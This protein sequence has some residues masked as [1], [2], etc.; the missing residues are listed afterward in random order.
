MNKK[1]LYIISASLLIAS[2]V[3]FVIA[4][5][6]FGDNTSNWWVLLIASAVFIA[7]FILTCIV[8]FRN[9]EFVCANCNKQFKPKTIASVMAVHIITKRL[10]HCPHCNKTTWAKETWTD[11]D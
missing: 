7:F 9:A 10:L 8:Y 6:L 11:L 4:S 1:T 3:G 2:I 5:M